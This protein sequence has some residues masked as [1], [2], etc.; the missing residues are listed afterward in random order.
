MKLIAEIVEIEGTCFCRG[1]DGQWWMGI[2]TPSTRVVDENAK[3]LELQ[4]QEKL[5]PRWAVVGDLH[6]G[7]PGAV[8]KARKF[9]GSQLK[10]EAPFAIKEALS[11]TISTEAPERFFAVKYC[12]DCQEEYYTENEDAF[13]PVCGGGNV[14]VQFYEV[15]K[16]TRG[17]R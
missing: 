3:V 17:N 2:P 8:E 12:I 13:C 14:E 7:D 11:V 6:A 15:E 1:T 9:L 16:R 5:A 10:R 4:Y